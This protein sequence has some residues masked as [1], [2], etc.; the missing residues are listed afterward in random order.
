M[1]TISFYKYQATGN[2][3]ILLDHTNDTKLSLGD[4]NLIQALCDRH[5]GIG[6]DGIIVIQKHPSYDFEMLF[7][8]PDG[9]KSFCGNGSRCA[10]HWAYQQGLI[11]SEASFLSTDSYHKAFMQGEWIYVYLVDVPLIKTYQDGYIVDTGSPH[12]VYLTDQLETLA[13]DNLGKAI[14]QD[15]LFQKSGTNVNFVQLEPNKQIRTRTYERGVFAETLSCG[16]GVVASALVAAQV[17][18]YTSPI[19][20]QTRGG[21]L[22]VGFQKQG[23]GYTDIY[24]A[25]PAARVFEG[26]YYIKPAS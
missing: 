23:D 5:F 13:I 12:Y 19:R 2:D 8:N 17:G 6:S 26:N 24:L 25:G 1:S 21:M 18:N 3:F 16:T 4:P 15:K 10:V 14:N 9:S 7:F 20:I 11:G 22:E